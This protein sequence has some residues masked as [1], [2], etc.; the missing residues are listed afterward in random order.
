MK[1][2]VKIKENQ[3]VILPVIKSLNSEALQ[4]E[5]RIRV[6][7][8]M[9]ELGAE[10]LEQEVEELC[11]KRYSREGAYYRHGQEP[12]TIMVEGAKLATTR[13]RVRGNGK[14]VKL[15]I[16]QSLRDQDVFD[17]Q[18][19]DLM[20]AGISTRKYD[21]VKEHLAERIGTKRST[22]SRAFDRASTK[23]LEEI[24]TGDLSKHRFVA[25]MIDGIEV[26]GKHL[27]AALGITEELVKVPIGLIQGASENAEVVRLLLEGLEERKFTLAGEKLLVVL[28]GSKALA[29]GVKSVF[30]ERA[31]VQ[32]CWI[33]KYRNIKAL[34]P[35]KCHT[36]LL[37]KMKK[38]MGL[39]SFADAK[40]ELTSLEHWLDEINPDA[41]QSLR[42]AGEDLLRLH[43][44]GVCGEL[45][46]S[47]SS[48]NLIE[49]LFSVVRNLC[50]RVKNWNGATTALRW[51]ASAIVAHKSKMRR[52][53]G[54]SQA[55]VLIRALGGLKN[56]YQIDS[57]AA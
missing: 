3:G 9:L 54:I 49:S 46:K 10:L 13:P 25:L 21:K 31:L 55:E 39:R 19:H 1:K 50:A 47:L 18:A 28:D 44:L 4:E 57:T 22:V 11:G 30:G 7:A 17:R 23:H 16:Y 12:C 29:A 14:E 26:R 48:T 41:A 20:M 42:E 53:R 37:W 35:E 6:R 34:I 51:S 52:L 56:Q 5:F 38:M 45:R 15:P 32:R 8:S 27:I 36:M 33:H 2:T 43:T 40:K 24:T